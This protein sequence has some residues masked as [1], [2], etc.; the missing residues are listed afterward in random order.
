MPSTKQ[1]SAASYK[2]KF[3]PQLRI[4]MTAWHFRSSLTL[5]DQD[6]AQT[7]YLTD[8]ISINSKVVLNLRLVKFHAHIPCAIFSLLHRLRESTKIYS[9]TQE[10]LK[11]YFP[12]KTNESCRTFNGL[13]LKEV[14]KTFISVTYSIGFHR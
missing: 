9:V 13:A 7:F 2:A 10:L 11:I 4:Q 12:N 8:H 3:G 5:T 1:I 14:L 6:R